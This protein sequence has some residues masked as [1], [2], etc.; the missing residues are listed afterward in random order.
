ME[1]FLLYLVYSLGLRWLIFQY[2]KT[3][4]IRRFLTSIKVRPLGSLAHELLQ[5]CYC[6]M[7]EASTLVYLA[8]TLLGESHLSLIETLLAIAANGWIMVVTEY[9]FESSINKMEELHEF[10]LRK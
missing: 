5:C 2:K 3:A 4:F 7:I 8:L 9:F 10:Y 1:T 6:Q